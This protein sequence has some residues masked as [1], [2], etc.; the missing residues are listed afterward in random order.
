MEGPMRGV[1]EKGEGKFG[2]IVGLV[3]LGL[4]GYF[5]AN[6]A[7]VYFAD[8]ELG[9]RIGAAALG[10]PTP[11]ADQ[12]SREKVWAAVQ[13]LDLTDYIPKNGIAVSTYSGKRRIAVSYE[14]EVTFLPGY[15]KVV[16]FEHH[17]D[18]PVF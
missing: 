12:A 10:P 14:R 7:P 11:G 3:V 1:K 18:Q 16:Q 8:W 6:A 13:E 5:L 9:D 17:V 4:G 2:L 15:K